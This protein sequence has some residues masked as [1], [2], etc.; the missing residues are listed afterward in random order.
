MERLLQTPVGKSGRPVSDFVRVHPALRLRSIDR[1]NQARVFLLR[2][3]AQKYSLNTVAE[4]A[5]GV[6]GS[7]SW[8]SGYRAY[9][10]GS[11]ESARRSARL[12]LLAFIIS[13][14]LVYLLLASQF[15]S[16][17][18]PFVIMLTVPLALIGVG[19]A[20]WLTGQ[21]LN[22]MAFIG[23]V[24]VVGIVVNDGIVKIEFIER[25]RRDG[26]SMDAAI[27]DA[28]KVRLRPILM[29]TVTTVAG[30]LPLALGLTGGSELQRP[31]AIA[32]V[33]GV[34]MATLLTLFVLPLLY[35]ILSRK[36]VR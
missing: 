34:S 16:L 9:L 27:L 14:I 3:T 17:R 32:I 22:I 12:L 7:M 25:R 19:P 31:M 20:L 5:Q 33:G 29:T 26:L 21:T 36:K 13:V 28:G 1:H 6:I 2:L 35:K 4:K 15:E 11:W 8:P 23:L 10:G 18:I 24:V 30:L